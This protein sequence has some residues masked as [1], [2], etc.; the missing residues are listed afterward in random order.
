M[1]DQKY[2]GDVF[3]REQPQA[4]LVFVRS[5]TVKNEDGPIVKR[6][7][8]SSERLPLLF[9]VGDGYFNEPALENFTVDE[10]CFV[11]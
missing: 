7:K 8:L 5:A 6:A 1:W 10:T 9:D 2:D 3:L 4:S 11:E